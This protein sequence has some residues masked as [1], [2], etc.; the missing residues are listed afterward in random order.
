MSGEEDAEERAE[1]KFRIRVAGQFIKDTRVYKPHKFEA[2]FVNTIV[3]FVAGET[4]WF[5]EKLDGGPSC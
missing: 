4:M 1:K 5:R 2:Q 3:R